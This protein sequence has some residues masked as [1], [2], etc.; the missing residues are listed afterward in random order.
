MA[1][2]FSASGSFAGV[3]GIS[4]TVVSVINETANYSGAVMIFQ[5][6]A[7]PTG[8]VKLTNVNDAMLGI[9]T[10]T[11]TA[12][13]STNFTTRFGSSVSIT[14]TVGFSSVT[15]DGAT[16]TTTQIPPHTHTF[17]SHNSAVPYRS[18]PSTPPLTNK[19]SSRIARGGLGPDITGGTAGQSHGHPGPA[20]ASSPVTFSS[21]DLRLKYVDV[22]YA[23]YT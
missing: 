15:V 23:S 22:I 5:Q 4:D 18:V 6:T 14:A 13:G 9:T 7:A 21:K 20:S 10:G 16:L 11:P 2:R 3:Y 19:V 8:W 17:I 12:S 1:P